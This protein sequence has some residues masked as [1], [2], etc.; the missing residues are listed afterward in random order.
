MWRKGG[1]G[2]PE[3]GLLAALLVTPLTDSSSG[4]PAVGRISSLSFYILLLK[5]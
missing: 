1:K 5:T 2:L 4:F 3:W